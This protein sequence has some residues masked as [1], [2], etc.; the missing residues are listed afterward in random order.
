MKFLF[1]SLTING[2]DFRFV[3]QLKYL[4]D[5]LLSCVQ[6]DQLDDADIQ[7]KVFITSVAHFGYTVEIISCIL[8]LFFD[9]ALRLDFSTLA[10]QT[11]GL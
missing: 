1:Q 2:C 8:C 5:R 4:E 3:V 6:N 7:R 10:Q 11:F 9:I